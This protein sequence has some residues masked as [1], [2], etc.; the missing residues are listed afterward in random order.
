MKNRWP[1]D[2][3]N[4]IGNSQSYFSN[5]TITTT[6]P[7]INF[8]KDVIWVILEN[9]RDSCLNRNSCLKGKEG[10]KVTV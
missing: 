6:S 10:T 3:G 7:R 9:F 8:P 4:H 1:D 2:L 5:G